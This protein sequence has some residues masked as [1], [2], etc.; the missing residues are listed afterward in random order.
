MCGVVD[1]GIVTGLYGYEAGQS[2]VGDIFGWF[3]ANQVPAVLRARR[4][5]RRH[6]RPRAPHRAGRRAADRRPR[7]RGP[8][9]VE[10]QPLGPRRPRPLRPRHGDDAHDPP[11]G[12]LPRAAGVHGVRRP[13]HRRD[14]RRIRACRSPSSSSPAACRRT[15]CSCRS[16]PTC[17][18]CRSRSSPRPRARRSARPSTPPSPPAPTPTSRPPP[19]R[20][21]AASTPR[22]PPIAENVAAYDRLYAVYREL[23]DHFGRTSGAMRTLKAIRRE[24]HA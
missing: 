4:P 11:R 1:G 5:R 3:V 9:L 6:R 8:G 16:T 12:R 24:A 14:L 23:H 19:R 21:A 17:S 22:S 18:T 15:P 7:P 20:W 13:R 2:G 10:R